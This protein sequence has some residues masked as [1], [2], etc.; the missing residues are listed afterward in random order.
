[1]PADIE[2]VQG[3]APLTNGMGTE[4]NWTSHFKPGEKVRLRLIYSSA[5]TYLD[6][7]IPG[8]EMTVVQP[9]EAKAYGIITESMGH[10]AW[11]VDCFHPLRVMQASYHGCGHNH[12][13]PWPTWAA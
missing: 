1:M 2:D 4:Q 3:F 6:V 7:R 8:L 11:C 13:C 5:M 10:T 12:C 9:R